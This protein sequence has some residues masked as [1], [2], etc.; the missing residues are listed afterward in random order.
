M[1][2]ANTVTVCGLCRRPLL[3]YGS[4][5]ICGCSN[6]TETLPSVILSGENDS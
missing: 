1:D 2:V 6:T 3:P 5:V 4:K